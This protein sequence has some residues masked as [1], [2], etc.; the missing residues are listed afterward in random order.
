M[1]DDPD[2][3][4][5]A[6]AHLL[7]ELALY[8]HRPFEDE[9]D[10]RPLPDARMAA[11]AI[12]DMFDALVA[13]L[14]ETRLEPDL[15]SLLWA[16][17]NLFHRAGERIER[18]LDDNEQA[19]R[20][21]VG[22]QDG[23]EVRSVELERLLLEGTT[24]IERRDAMD[25]FRETAAE[26][27]RLHTRQAWT[28]RTGSLVNRRT[29]TAAM[30]DSRDFLAAR[31]QA[32][33]TVL[34]PP[35][36]R[37]AITGGNAVQDGRRIWRALDKVRAKHPDM[38]LLHGGSPS[39]TDRI[40]DCWARARGVTVIQFRPDWARHGKAAPFKRN[41]VLLEQLPAGLL[42]FPGSGITA[43][44]VDKARKMGLPVWRFD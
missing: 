1:T 35:G 42:A 13:T 5:S 10:P 20:R 25:F 15:Q 22:E 3:N 37:I 6:T 27:Y 8:G 28:P 17:P 26:H 40:A 36:T 7:D 43:N 14:E 4:I 41:D 9:P 16:L 23:S 11:G 38:I 32:D 19:Q 30:I 39:G 12:A 2:L 44:L 31:R 34:L 18:A 24:L 33:R 29:L 21:S